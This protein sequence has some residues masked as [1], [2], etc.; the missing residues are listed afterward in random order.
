LA[1]PTDSNL[2]NEHYNRASNLSAAEKRLPA[3]NLI[4]IKLAEQSDQP[5]SVCS[6]TSRPGGPNYDTLV[7]NRAMSSKQ[8]HWRGCCKCD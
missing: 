5:P 2:I 1:A 8:P 4:W 3:I 7:R 6:L